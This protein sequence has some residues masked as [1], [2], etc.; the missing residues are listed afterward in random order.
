MQ[1]KVEEMI[2]LIRKTKSKGKMKIIFKSIENQ[3]FV[4]THY[5]ADF[6]S[7]LFHLNEFE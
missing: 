5:Y 1:E 7:Q 2:K 3:S 6:I 4:D